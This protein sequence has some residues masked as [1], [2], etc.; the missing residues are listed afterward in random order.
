MKRNSTTSK[1]FFIW[2]AKTHGNTY[3]KIGLLMYQK[4]MWDTVKCF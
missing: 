1:Y 2:N 3:F 4:R